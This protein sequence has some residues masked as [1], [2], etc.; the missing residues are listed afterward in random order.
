MPLRH[1]KNRAECLARSYNMWKERWL[2]AIAVDSC[3]VS[4]Y[5][6]FIIHDYFSVS[7]SAVRSAG[8][9]KMACAFHKCCLPKMMHSLRLFFTQFER[10]FH[11]FSCG[12]CK[13]SYFS[14]VIT[15]L[16]IFFCVAQF[17]YTNNRVLL[18]SC[19][20]FI[21]IEKWS[22]SNVFSNEMATP[23]RTL[24]IC[25]KKKFIIPSVRMWTV[26]AK[27]LSDL[28]KNSKT[29]GLTRHLL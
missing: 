28:G 11:L 23:T 10:F 17:E 8:T 7:L 15:G 4:L 29:Q 9:G 26:T 21:L 22:E 16:R 2:F 27:M 12:C 24:K 25:N 3:F 19:F 1:G 18:H 5:F 14:L 20:T 6:V 13:T